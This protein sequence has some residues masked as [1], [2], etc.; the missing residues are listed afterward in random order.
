MSPTLRSLLIALAASVVLA[1]C[2][3]IDTS[4]LQDIEK[5]AESARTTADDLNSRAPEIQSAIADPVGTLR[6]AALGATFTKT[7][8]AEANLFVLTDL[9]TGCQWLATYGP[10]GQAVSI[11]PRTEPGGTDT[12]QR[13]IAIN[14]GAR[15][16]GDGPQ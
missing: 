16:A 1:A 15:G 11:A 4:V 12:R 7:P 9:Q 10:D 8:T 6:A 2:E 13:C 14:G 5:A 3:P